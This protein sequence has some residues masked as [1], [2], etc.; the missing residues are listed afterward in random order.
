MKNLKYYIYVQTEG[1]ADRH[2]GK[3]CYKIV[4]SNVQNVKHKFVA[5]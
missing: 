3:Y 5:M 2:S 4:C 1:H